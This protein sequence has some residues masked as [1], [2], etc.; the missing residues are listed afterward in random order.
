MEGLLEVGDSNY[1]FRLIRDPDIIK[2]YSQDALGIKGNFQGVVRPKGEE[3]IL[4]VISYCHKT[5]TKLTPQGLR[6]SLTGASMADEG[7]ALCLEGMNRII[8]LDEN[9]KVA[10]VE[11]GV[12]TG[13]LS[14]LCSSLGLMYPPDPTSQK[15]CTIGGNVATN[16]SG[17]R[18]LK[19]G[20]TG[21]WVFY[22]RVIDGT[23]KIHELYTKKG[24]KSACGPSMFQNGL[25]LFVGSEGIFGIITKIGLKLIEAPPDSIIFVVFFE[26]IY[27]A[28]EFVTHVILHKRKLPTSME[29]LDEYCM[30][31]LEGKEGYYA[32]KD[33]RCI[34]YFEEDLWE[35]LNED[36]ILESWYGLIEKHTRFFE[37]TILLKSHK[38]KEVFKKLRHS[39]PEALN[40]QSIKATKQGGLKISTDWVVPIENIIKIFQYF[41]E[42]RPMLKDMP[43]ARYGHIGSGHPHFNIIARDH[44]EK[45]LAKEVEKRLILKALELGGTVS[46]EHGIGKLK[47]AYLGLMYPEATTNILKSVKN[48]MDPK[49]ILSPGNII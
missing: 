17:S 49:W 34:I 1:N 42:V 47:K 39:V 19:F 43:V 36:E 31:L 23:G 8:D 41:D 27:K 26:D 9:A 18:S 2:A 37:D 29:L 35:D 6:T 44:Q 38:Q 15:E 45:E 4:E 30:H 16:A 21:N 13:E 14:I 22:L 46:G 24:L 48:M 28:L 40:E 32:P 5:S 10:Y 7:I 33:S 20:P 25:D 12:P 11:P 3:E